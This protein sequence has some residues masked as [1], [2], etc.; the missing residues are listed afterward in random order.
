MADPTPRPER[1]SQPRYAVTSASGR[2]RLGAEFELVDVSLDGIGV[3]SVVPLQIGRVYTGTIEW[4]GERL[5]VSGRVAWSV[6]ARTTR[7]AE[8]DV[9]PVYHSGIHFSEEADA[10]LGERRRLLERATT[11]RPGDR[12]FGR[13]EALPDHT[14][15]ELDASFRIRTV[16]RRGMLI[17]A[18]EPLELGTELDLSIDLGSHRLRARGR[19]ASLDPPLEAEGALLHPAGIEFLDLEPEAAAALD[20][21]LAT[22]EP[23]G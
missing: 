23:A 9:L 4:E 6:L 10:A 16:S 7:G 12:L 8:G 1:R 15:L 18:A 21:Y 17:E 3:Q 13:Y 2:F 14:R 19:V 22:L 5:P 20:A 11:Y